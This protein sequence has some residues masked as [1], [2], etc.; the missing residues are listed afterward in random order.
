MATDIHLRVTRTV[1]RCTNRTWGLGPRCDAYL[2]DV[3]LSMDAKSELVRRGRALPP[4]LKNVCVNPKS[5]CA[6]VSLK[7]LEPV[8][9]LLSGG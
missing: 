5:G 8:L 1:N 4:D 9:D 3:S 7:A 6:L 2:C